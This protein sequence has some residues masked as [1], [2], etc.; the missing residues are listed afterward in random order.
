[1]HVN[2]SAPNNTR[3]SDSLGAA[4]GSG[5]SDGDGDG[6]SSSSTINE[7]PGTG[8]DTTAATRG[9]VEMAFVVAE[10]EDIV[11]AVT[12]CDA[13]NKEDIDVEDILGQAGSPQLVC[14]IAPSSSSHKRPSP[15]ALTVIEKTRNQKRSTPQSYGAHS[16]S[17]LSGLHSPSQSTSSLEVV[18][19]GA[20]DSGVTVALSGGVV[21]AL[22]VVNIASEEVVTT[23]V[24]T[25]I[26][27]V[28]TIE[29][30]TTDTHIRLYALYDSAPVASE[31]SAG[32]S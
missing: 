6:S 27:V 32:D 19:K 20:G 16:V 23:L 18:E 28:V 1:V 8:A 9:V 17:L 13:L 5:L 10:I 12:V 3:V 15:L 29:V 14:C 7:G 24:D 21:E 22:G 11:V 30:D 4:D 25:L 2:E 26:V 31:R